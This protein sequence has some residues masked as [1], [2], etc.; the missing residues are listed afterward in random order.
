MADVELVL[1]KR[2]MAGD[3]GLL[4][5]GSGSI[6]GSNRPG[7]EARLLALASGWLRVG[8]AARGGAGVAISAKRPPPVSRRQLAY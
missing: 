4:C 3:D 6:G 2:L 1:E 7:I 5:R 8:G